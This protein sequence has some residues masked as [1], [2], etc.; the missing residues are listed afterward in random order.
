MSYQKQLRANLVAELSRRDLTQTEAAR[1][2]NMP[3]TALSARLRGKIDFRI[4]ELLALADLVGVPLSAL[5]D[6]LQEADERFGREP[7]GG[8]D[9]GK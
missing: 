7:E 6:G 8:R 5:M 4:G 1:R 3:Q 2:L 9:A